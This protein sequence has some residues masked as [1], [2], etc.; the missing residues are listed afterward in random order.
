MRIGIRV[1]RVGCPGVVGQVIALR[2]ATAK[3]KWSK[4]TSAWA[5]RRMLIETSTSTVIDERKQPN[6]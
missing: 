2:S 1:V 3:V 4:H 6:E 5:N